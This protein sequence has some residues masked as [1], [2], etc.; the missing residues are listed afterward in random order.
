VPFDE[1]RV[2][3]DCGQPWCVR[4]RTYRSARRLGGSSAVR[5]PGAFDQLLAVGQSPG[6]TGVIDVLQLE[7][8]DGLWAVVMD[9]VHHVAQCSLLGEKLAELPTAAS[10][11]QIES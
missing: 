3:F 9:E 6:L 8:G 10:I 2:D 5:Q 11:D 4:W 1:H 7:L